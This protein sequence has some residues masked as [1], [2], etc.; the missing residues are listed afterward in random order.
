MLKIKFGVPLSVLLTKNCNAFCKFCI[1][2]T[3]E[4]TIDKMTEGQFSKNINILAK[5]G[6]IK[7]VLLL[8]GEPLIFPNIVHL[9]NNLTIPP[10]VTS[11]GE[12]FINNET[13]RNSLIKSNM[14]AINISI[15][16]YNEQKRIELCGR[17]LFTNDA[18]KKVMLSL[19]IEMK[20]KI[21]INT[22]F[23][24]GYCDSYDEINNM[25]SFV[26]D[27]GLSQIKFL[28][29]ISDDYLSFETQQYIQTH[30]V[31]I[32]DELDEM[33]SKNKSKEN[34]GRVLWKTQN[35]VDIYL[36]SLPVPSSRYVMFN[37][38]K[39]GCSWTKSNVTYEF[40]EF[41]KNIK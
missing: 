29:M 15:H 26:K 8:G 27:I 32:S 5:Y 31:F 40:D 30:H 2:R 9:I 22:L 41:I 39:I 1:E 19:P 16:H 21:T 23:I 17:N 3:K 25:V 36:Q 33:I 34:K 20:N 4:M 7:S 38:G 37:D 11:N 14:K 24:K 12:R 18:L 13:L 6:I 35:N 28:R 10:Y